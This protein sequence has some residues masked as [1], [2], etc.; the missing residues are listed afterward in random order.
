M[1]K[2]INLKK[3]FRETIYQVKEK[4]MQVTSIYTYM[5]KLSNEAKNRLLQLGWERISEKYVRRNIG[6]FQVSL[7]S[8]PYAD[9]L[10]C[11]L[12]QDELV[13]M[14]VDSTPFD[15]IE[16]WKVMWS[17][18]VELLEVHFFAHENRIDELLKK[19]WERNSMF[20]ESMLQHPTETQMFYMERENV[21]DKRLYFEFVD[22]QKAN[23][24]EYPERLCRVGLLR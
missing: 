6:N 19:G 4:D 2:Y 22:S 10:I 17:K 8:L 12:K 24:L 18:N 16:G 14:H 15:F 23:A 1:L 13:I 5:D 3:A 21:R 20:P 11:S 9:Q 7:V